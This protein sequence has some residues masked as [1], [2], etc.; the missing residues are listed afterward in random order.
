[1]SLVSLVALAVTVTVKFDPSCKFVRLAWKVS[2]EVVNVRPGLS[3][4]IY[5]NGSLRHLKFPAATRR[6]DDRFTLQVKMTRS[7]GHANCLPSSST[8]DERL[9][10]TSEMGGHVPVIKSNPS[11]DHN[12]NVHQKLISR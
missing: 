3:D 12:L 1:M 6:Y 11:G 7:P 9:T 5:V 4:S 10:V 8:L 2:L